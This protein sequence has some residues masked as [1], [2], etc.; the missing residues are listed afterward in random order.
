MRLTAA[1][2]MRF[3]GFMALL[4]AVGHGTLFLRAKPA[5][6]PVEVA[7]VE[8]MRSNTFTFAMAPR[9]YWDMYTG[10]GLESAAICVA[11]GALFWLLAGIV[12]REPAGVL[13]VLV[14]F[15]VANLVHAV[16]VWHY[17]AFPIPVVFDGVIAAGL[18]GALVLAGRDRLGDRRA[19]PIAPTVT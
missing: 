13:P 2:L 10:Y 19:A 5:H 15:V 14:L 11:E 9:S 8:A 16:L 6:G 12:K 7:V 17:F 1:A 4:Q 3:V 18:A